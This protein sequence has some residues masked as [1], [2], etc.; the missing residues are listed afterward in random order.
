MRKL[1]RLFDL[2]AAADYSETEEAGSYAVRREGRRLTILFEGSN[3]REDWKH[4]FNFPAKPYHEM[5][6]IWF[7]HRGFLK[8]FR[9][10]EPRLAPLI[11][12]GKVREIVIAGYSHGAALALLCH[13][14]ALFHRPDLA[15]AIKGYGF[16]C[17]RV[18][19]LRPNRRVR[20][21]FKDFTVIRN[22]CDLVTRL[23]P[24]LF[25]FRHVGKLLRLCGGGGPIRAH[26]P[27][28]YRSGLE[29]LESGASEK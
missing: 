1:S 18:V 20:A 3:G 16:G 22:G 13:E 24:A 15:G 4:N 8:V 28:R 7:V 17:P 26:D 2:I 29:R 27:E 19:W 10:I 23:P 21:R 14:Y 11:G 6:D 25:G 5:R 9:S 12:D